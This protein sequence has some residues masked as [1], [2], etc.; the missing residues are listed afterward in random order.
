MREE[1]FQRIAGHLL[2]QDLSNLCAHFL[3]CNVGIEA[4]IWS[5]EDTH[6]LL[7]LGLAGRCLRILIELQEQE[8]GAAL[9]TAEA[10]LY[11]LDIRKAQQI[12]TR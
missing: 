6:L 4:G 9:A 2:F 3:S 10:I 5:V 7:K 12:A 1:H 8:T 11:C